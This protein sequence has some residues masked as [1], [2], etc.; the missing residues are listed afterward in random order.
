VDVGGS[1]IVAVGGTDVGEGVV[2]AVGGA[3]VG[4][5]VIV[6]V[7]G[8][9][10]GGG[11]IVAESGALGAQAVASNEKANSSESSRYASIRPMSIVI[12][13]LSG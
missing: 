13:H 3:A 4:G 12:S 11:V 7:G 2:V 8:A 10:V 6:A 9:A 5:G 1:F